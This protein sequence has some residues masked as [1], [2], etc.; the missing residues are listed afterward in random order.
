MRP[1]PSCL[2]A[3]ALALAACGQP[4]GAVSPTPSRM[5][6]GAC[7]TVRLPTRSSEDIVVAGGVAFISS[8]PGR[9]PGRPRGAI[10]AY[11]LAR[12][13]TP[14]A[15]VDSARFPDFHPHGMGL[16]TGED[17]ERRL[18]VVNHRGT[19]DV[20]E[21][22]RVNGQRLEH[23]DSA[24]GPLLRRGNDVVPVGP[25]SFYVTN[26]HTAQGRGGMARQTLF[27]R[28][29]SYVL[30]YD[31]TTFSK[32]AEG[33]TFANGVNVSADGTRLYV[34]TSK[35]RDL[36]TYH[37]RADGSLSPAQHI[38]LATGPDNID[39]DSGGGLWVA[40][41]RNLTAFGLYAAKW[42]KTSPSQVLYFP[43]D[44]RRLGRPQLVA[45]RSLL[46]ATSVAVRHGNRLLIGTVSDFALDC[47]L[48]G[49]PPP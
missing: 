4:R 14:T 7:D 49:G 34:T 20:I 46:P 35:G 36:R 24:Y 43:N 28:G 12:R 9:T 27:K 8:D 3:V 47:P 45:E 42:R 1:A 23:V 22:F 39:V 2:A 10:Y 40:S 30:F 11:D 33:L 48:A 21:I 29:Y 16:F 26:S 6:L 18:F 32:A 44:G 13:G 5:T 37:R 17:G 41:H 38:Q 25:R 15:V 19:G 31:G